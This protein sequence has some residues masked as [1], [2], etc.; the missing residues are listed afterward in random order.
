M[1]EILIQD[2]ADEIGKRFWTPK[3]LNALFM[4]KV[5]RDGETMRNM[6]HGDFGAAE[7]IMQALVRYYETHDKE[8]LIECVD[9]IAYDYPYVCFTKK[10]Q[11]DLNRDTSKPTK[12]ELERMRWLAEFSEKEQDKFWADERL[13]EEAGIF[14]KY[15]GNFFYYNRD[16]HYIVDESKP[17]E[18]YENKLPY[19]LFDE[20]YRESNWLNLALY[21]KPHT[22]EIKDEYAAPFPQKKYVNATVIDVLRQTLEKQKTAVYDCPRTSESSLDKICAEIYAEDKLSAPK[23]VKAVTMLNQRLTKA[24]KGEEQL[25]KGD[26]DAVAMLIDK[27]P[28]YFEQIDY[29]Q[30]YGFYKSDAGKELMK[31]SFMTSFT[32]RKRF[33]EQAMNNYV[34]AVANAGHWMNGQHLMTKMIL[35]NTQNLGGIN[36]GLLDLNVIRPRPQKF[37]GMESPR[38]LQ[39]LNEYYNQDLERAK[40]PN[41]IYQKPEK[42][43][44]KFNLEQGR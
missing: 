6:I 9:N 3:R 4:S 10:R 38:F 34:D 18:I 21:D 44:M 32:R 40:Y 42:F 24:L 30:Q 29:A 33:S 16:G 27:A 39:I 11:E 13:Y 22:I 12:A 35:K 14:A 23:F 19:T 36:R 31:F 15:Y 17:I 8:E 41:L 7:E 2:I 28:Q 5:M 37:N 1:P 25:H 20:T 26:F 43:F